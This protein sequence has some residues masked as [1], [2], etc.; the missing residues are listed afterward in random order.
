MYFDEYA[1]MRICRHV[2][3]HICSGFRTSILNELDDAAAAD[4]AGTDL[5]TF[6][7]ACLSTCVVHTYSSAHVYTH[8]GMYLYT[9][10]ARQTSQCA[11]LLYSLQAMR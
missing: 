2:Y 1:A 4:L 9:D 5:S 11:P 10:G 6:L 8:A 7:H 3:A